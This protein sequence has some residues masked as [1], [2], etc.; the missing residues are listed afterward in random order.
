MRRTAAVLALFT[1]L[2]GP[3]AVAQNIAGS[4]S[5]TVVDP[6]GLAVPGATVVLIN[7]RT[8]TRIDSTSNEQG[9]FEFLS[10]LPSTYDVEVEMTGFKRLLRSGQVLSANQRLAT[11]PL[12]LEIGG[13][14]ESVTVSGRVEAVQTASA[15]RSGVI[16]RQQ[17][18]NLQVQ[19]RDPIELWAKLPGV[20][21]DGAGTA[22][23]Q[24]P[25][26][27]RDISIMGARRNNKNITIDGVT[28]MNTV[29]N[30]AMTV[31]PNLDSVEEVQVLLSNYQAEYG[32][33]AGAG[34]NI[35]TRS[36]S[37][38]YHGGVYF[39]MKHEKLNATDFFDNKFGRTKPL[40]RSQTRGA[41]IGGP[42]FIPGVFNTDKKKL[43]F[44]FS[45][46][47]QPFK[48]PQALQQVQMPTALERAGDFSQTFDQAGRLILIRDPLKTGAC[49]TADQTACF[50][51]NIIPAS[52]L[53]QYGV[54]L[55]KIFPLPNTTDSLRRFNFS[56]SGTQYQQPRRSNVLKLDYNLNSRYTLTGRY[57]QDG[58]DVITDYSSNFSITNTRLARPGKNLMFRVNQLFSN[59]LV[60]ETTFGY[61]RLN[62]ATRPED[63]AA[64]SAITRGTL[65]VT[66]GQIKPQNNPLN[67][68]PNLAFGNIISG[69]A[70][71]T[72]SN[73]FS[74][75]FMTHVTVA[76]NVSK[77]LRSH[78]LKFGVYFERTVT[79][80]FPQG[81][82]GALNFGVAA[83]N[84][85][86]SGYAY[87][88]AVLGNFQ[89][90]TE[91]TIRR[92]STFRFTD[93]EWYAQ[94]NWRLN[95]KLTLDYGMRF[96][97]HPPETESSD[98][99]SS[100][101][102]SR[103]DPSKAVRLYLPATATTARDPLTGATVSSLLNY[104]I[105]PGSGD[106]NNGIATQSAGGL[107]EDR[108][109]ALGPRLGFAYDPWGDGKTAIRGGFGVF[110][111]RLAGATLGLLAENAP[112]VLTPIIYNSNLST[113]LNATG[114]VFPGNLNGIS[115]DG[116]LATTMNY[117]L[118]VQRRIGNLF[119]VDVA[120]AASLSRHLPEIRDY[121]TLPAAARFL[122]SNE[123]PL[124]PGRAWDDRYL[125]PYRG[126][127]AI[128]VTEMTS[129]SNYHSMQL[130]ITRRFGNR[131]NFDG[132]YTWSRALNYAAGDQGQRSILLPGGRDYGRAD[133]AANHVFNLNYMYLVPG[134]SRFLGGNKIV[135]FVLDNWRLSGITQVMSGY[136]MAIALNA[137]TQDFTGSNEVA[138]V[139]ITGVTNLPKDERTFSRH[140][141]T[142]AI[143][144]P[145]PGVFGVTTAA[146]VD[147]GNASKDV[148]NQPGFSYWNAAI[149]K[150]FKVHENHRFQFSAE[151]YNFPN[152]M[153]FRRVNNLATFN[154]A[155]VQ[156]NAAFGEYNSGLGPRQI[157]LG[158]RY[159][160]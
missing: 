111:D 140:F 54:Q 78:V 146:T 56:K 50:S 97:W 43:F 7:T 131:L 105:V 90:Y 108:G 34:I 49:T 3:M 30:Q 20:I 44:F 64:V 35:I 82:N 158:L 134:V 103:F 74:S 102:L 87:A 14:Q 11:G 17:I 46:S 79:D 101:A 114:A 149:T 18:D 27:V 115:S 119:A 138:R 117:S 77:V 141:N 133:I 96:Y 75:D 39:Y 142:G 37:R 9:F 69:L 89:T 57:A 10:L 151:F 144:R 86:D 2:A 150:V 76:D 26:S 136:P 154:A 42:V 125:R 36:G 88:N 31:T 55:L 28:A 40:S 52:R 160:F 41:Q 71:P 61:D 72:F 120:Y 8:G 67:L 32:R 73:V 13:T 155:G 93:L 29:T 62:Q 25:Q 33:S 66:L 156:T 124:T 116:H 122:R 129:N 152:H 159:D 94:D 157:Q 6:K 112:Q 110:Y 68:I 99:M 23:L 38:D 59:N 109:I 47:Q 53:D 83:T 80:R 19:S 91:P 148:F 100:A 5:G 63:D 123:N 113:F 153:S 135:G 104:A 107:V 1:A 4:I 132:N 130:G 21:T 84:P 106:L 92:E 137:G 145:T 45:E 126:Y 15:E 60:N 118:G 85:N 98:F 95:R 65:G 139:N 51:G 143:A 127:N 121:N 147:Y 58:N 16:T 81:G 128:L 70:A 48:L 22:A 12:A 24:A